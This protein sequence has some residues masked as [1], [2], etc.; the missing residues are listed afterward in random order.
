MPTARS[1]MPAVEIAGR[2]YVPG[3]FSGPLGSGRL[4]A[5][6]IATDTW[7]RLADMPQARHHLMATAHAG[8]LYVLGGSAP[9]G[10]SATDSAWRYDPAE[11]RWTELPSMPERRMSGAAVTLG[12]QI[13]VVGGV[14]GSQDLLVF[15]LSSQS[16]SRRSGPLQPSEHTAAVAYQAELWLIAGRWGG[17]GEL[18]RVEIYDPAADQWREGPPL[19]VARGGF[20]AATDGQ[21]IFVAGG[22]V[23]MSGN[24]TL[25][26]VELFDPALGT[27]GSGSDLL[28]PVHGVDAVA[29]AG[30]FLVMGGSERAGGI[31]NQGRVQ[32]YAP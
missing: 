9:F 2:V 13:M 29:H 5:Y 16:W 10:F 8:V 23:I 12:E 28:F 26:S 4:E 18:T 24:L 30:R 25:A 7:Q 17:V 3:G 11:D 19:Q 6:Q 20:A 15:D 32:I 27:W 21:R 14:G 31:D 1:E 22:E